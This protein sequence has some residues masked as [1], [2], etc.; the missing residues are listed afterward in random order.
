MVAVRREIV[1]GVIIAGLFA[2]GQV[3]ANNLGI[4][5]EAG[6]LISL[7]PI[8]A[9]AGILGVNHLI[10]RGRNNTSS[11]PVSASDLPGTVGKVE[12]TI[13]KGKNSHIGHDT[14]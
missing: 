13:P 9:G 4:G 12:A 14:K 8:L 10:K 2:A 7:A 3:I 1:G 5:Y 6:C 11:L